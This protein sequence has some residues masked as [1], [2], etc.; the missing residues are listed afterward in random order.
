MRAEQVGAPAHF[1]F[2]DKH[3]LRQGGMILQRSTRSCKLVAARQN[4]QGSP[5]LAAL[6]HAALPVH[7]AEDGAWP[8]SLVIFDVPAG[9]GSDLRGSASFLGRFSDISARYLEPSAS[10]DVRGVLTVPA[11]SEQG[12]FDNT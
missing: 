2:H 5:A 7:S 12:K 1:R 10:W 8:A 6:T 11:P 3:A 4:C 9:A